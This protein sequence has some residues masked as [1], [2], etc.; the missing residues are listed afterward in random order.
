MSKEAISINYLQETKT[1]YL[2]D[3]E[4]PYEAF[5]VGSD[6]QNNIGANIAKLLRK[7]LWT[8]TEF[9]KQNCV[10]ITHCTNQFK[11]FL[12]NYT[13]ILLTRKENLANYLKNLA[14]HA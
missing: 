6:K 8:V 2:S 3:N 9:E 12:K 10:N 11:Y 4:Y 5:V 7:K 1:K 13:E 14:F